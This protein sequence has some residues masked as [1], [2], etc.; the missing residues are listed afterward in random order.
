MR[1]MRGFRPGGYVGP[2]GHPMV[3]PHSMRRRPVRGWWPIWGWGP[4]TWGVG[5]LLPLVGM[6][7][8]LGLVFLRLV[9]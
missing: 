1:G 4:Y 6:A 7:A 5:C 9:F 2:L 8:I 3:C